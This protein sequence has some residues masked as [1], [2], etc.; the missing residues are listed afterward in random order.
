MVWDII[1]D[2]FLFYVFRVDAAIEVQSPIDV[3]VDSGCWYD[4][5]LKH[6]KILQ[7]VPVSAHAPIVPI[8]GWKPI[9]SSQDSPPSSFNEGHM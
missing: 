1:D 4:E 3:S 2:T 7:P 6:K 5:K 8:T 9:V